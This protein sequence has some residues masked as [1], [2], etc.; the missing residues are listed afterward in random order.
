MQP[1]DGESEYDYGRRVVSWLNE[2]SDVDWLEM[3]R[4]HLDSIKAAHDRLYARFTESRESMDPDV[5]YMMM[6][7]NRVIGEVNRRRAARLLI[8]MEIKG[9]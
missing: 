3:E 1:R 7:A 9:Q 6:C 2:M 5:I 8:D 4:E